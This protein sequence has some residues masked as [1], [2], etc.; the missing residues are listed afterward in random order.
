MTI[1][2]DL[3]A[4]DMIRGMSPREVTELIKEID[5]EI[6]DCDFS[7]KLIKQLVDALECDMT[8]EDIAEELGFKVKEGE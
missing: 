2:L 4:K 7:V 8:R 5:A 3:S 6:G 1:Y